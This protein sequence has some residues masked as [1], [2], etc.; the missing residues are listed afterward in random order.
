MVPV[1][2]LYAQML[3]AQACLQFPFERPFYAKPRWRDAFIVVDFGCGD[4]SYLDL[5]AREFPEKRYFGVESNEEMRK[6]AERKRRHD[7]ISFHSSLF[8]ID[9][10]AVD[11][12]LLRYVVMHLDD[13]ARV[14]ESIR[15]RAAGEAG[16]LIIEPDDHKL[17]INPPFSLL[18]DA[19]AR[20]QAASKHRNLREQ[21]DDELEAIG[22]SLVEQA[23]PT[24]SIDAENLDHRILRYAYSLIELGLQ[25]KISESQKA[26][27][28][29]WGLERDNSVQFGFDGRLYMRRKSRSPYAD[30]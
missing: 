13:R 27:L 1:M 16:V 9:A 28:L 23:S 29:D 25:A 30:P 21:L 26:S 10:S 14:F 5:L 12:F 4:G 18:E 19:V 24:I 11:F 22:F 2:E 3:E 20:M 8:E 15:E 17:K 7:N 6:I